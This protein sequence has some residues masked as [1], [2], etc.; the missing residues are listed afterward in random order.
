MFRRAL[1]ESRDARGSALRRW[2]TGVAVSCLIALLYLAA[3]AATMP[4]SALRH[5]VSI[6]PQIT[7]LYG[8][9]RHGRAE[10]I[11]GYALAWDHRAGDLLRLGATV[12]L[13]VSGADTQLTGTLRATPL[14]VAVT[15][16][17]GRAG[18]GLLAL[19]PGVAVE[20]CTTRAVVDVAQLRLSRGAAAAEGN[21]AVDAGTCTET[22]GRIDPVPP[23]ALAL[24]TVG[25]DAQAVVTSDGTTL[26]QIVVAGDRRLILTL[27][28]EGSALIPGLP[29]GAPIMLEYP[30]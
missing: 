1:S 13:G 16:L 21:V 19:A 20:S 22:N 6:P 26:A 18:A 11:G 15:D 25:N 2:M 14:S 27:Q 28:P 8:T 24:D 12:D 7:A 4:A 30:F 10:M 5:F 3:L 17:A 29:T 9:L 23:L